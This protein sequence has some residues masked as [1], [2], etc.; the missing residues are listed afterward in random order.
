MVADL[1]L[2]PVRDKGVA[3]VNCTDTRLTDCLLGTRGMSPT[4]ANQREQRPGPCSRALRPWSLPTYARW[5]L[6]PRL[7]NNAAHDLSPRDRPAPANTIL[8]TSAASRQTAVHALPMQIL[9]RN[10]G[11]TPSHR[12]SICRFNSMDW[13][14]LQ[15]RR[16]VSQHAVCGCE[17][18]CQLTVTGLSWSMGDVCNRTIWIEGAGC[19]RTYARCMR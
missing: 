13:R 11:A 7:C 6:C 3:C 14:C 9:P 8:Q 12:H 19:R 2:P 18:G 15:A 1:N 4:K 17:H 5:P 10:F 16:R